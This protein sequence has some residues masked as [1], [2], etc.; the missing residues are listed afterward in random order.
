M[1]RIEARGI[2]G[3]VHKRRMDAATANALYERLLPIVRRR[4]GQVCL[5]CNDELVSWMDRAGW[6]L[7]TPELAA[8]LGSGDLSN[9]P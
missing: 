1:Y 4:G 9:L 8:I 2:G 6:G 5:Y 3:T 7:A